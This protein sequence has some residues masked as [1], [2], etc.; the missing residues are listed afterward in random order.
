MTT[1]PGAL[2][3]AVA[4]VRLKNMTAA[5]VRPVLDAE[6]L[7]ALLASFAIQDRWG[8]R[9][10]DE[11]WEPTWDLNA[12]AAEGWRWKAAAVA[13][14]FTFSADDGSFS[15]GEVMAK[16]LAMAEQYAA[17]GYGTLGA[18]DDR[19]HAAYNSPRLVL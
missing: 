9:V 4:L 11:G 16:C 6:T 13:A 12:A 15:K 14:D 10:Q 2:D 5:T 3:P 1:A 7:T 18:R 17:K 8:A 19:A